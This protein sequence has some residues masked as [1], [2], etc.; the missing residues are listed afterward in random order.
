MKR[1]IVIKTGLIV[2]GLLVLLSSW[3][4]N[5]NQNKAWRDNGNTPGVVTEQNKDSAVIKQLLAELDARLHDNPKDYEAS[6]LKGLFYFKQG[7]FNRAVKLLRQLTQRAPEFHLA[8]LVYGDLLLAQVGVV[9][10]V[11]KSPIF[12]DLDNKMSK[13]LAQLREEAQ[14]RLQANLNRLHETR[15]PRQLLKLGSSVDKAILVEKSTHRLYVYER[16]ADL[17]P[18][19]KVY[20]YYVS[21]GRKDGNKSVQGDLRTPEGVYFVTKYIPDNKLPDKYGVGA[22]PVSYPN[23]WDRHLGKTGEGIW[24]HGTAS[25]FYSRPPR[26]SEG[27]VVLTNIDLGF[28][29]HEIKPGVTPV[30]IANRLDWVNYKVWRQEQ[31]NLIAVIDR[32][33]RDWESLD[34]NRYLSNYAKDFWTHGYNFVSWS[35]RKMRVAVNKKYQ[36]VKISDL[37]LFVYPVVGDG[38]KEMAVARFHQQYRSNNYQ[39]DTDKRLYLTHDKDEWR[40][41]Y[42]GS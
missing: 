41:L 34:V 22:F 39:S 35:Q 8:H 21:T 26:D 1:S 28:I 3:L 17:K 14:F 13:Q 18:P 5:A 32:W 6:L 15:I 33:R 38:G 37:S 11:G 27:C 25:D 36:K 10:D 9:T 40:I 2:T 31:K 30:I 7:D 16:Q 19:L 20:D 12:K 24:L 23:E 29:Q 4:V 42:E